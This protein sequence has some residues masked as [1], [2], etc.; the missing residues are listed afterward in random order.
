MKR[1]K[2]QDFDPESILDPA[3]S[4]SED[5]QSAFGS[6]SEADVETGRE[7]YESVGKSKLRKKEVVPLGPQY[8]GSRVRRDEVEDDDSDDPFAR[9]Y[10][11]SDEDNEDE[12]D[13]GDIGSDEDMDNEELGDKDSEDDEEGNEDDDDNESE[14][15]ESN[16]S[17]D[18]TTDLASKLHSLMNEAKTVNATISAGRKADESKGIAIKTQRKIFDSLLNTRVKLQK[19]LVATNS[20]STAS[21]TESSSDE[22][23]AAA[24]AACLALLSTLTNLRTT[25]DSSRIGQKRKRVNYEPTTSSSEIRTRLRQDDDA[26]APHRDAVLQKWYTKTRSTKV[27]SKERLL[28]A[29]AQQT[30]PDVLATQLQNPARL[31]E[32]TRVNRQAGSTNSSSAVYDDSDWYSLLLKD[33]LENRSSE[34]NGSAEFVVRQPWEMIRQ[35]KTKKVV[36]TK[37]SKGR[38]LRYTVHEKLQNFMAPE[39]RGTWGERQRDDLFAGLFGRRAGLA[40]DEPEGSEDE[41]FNAEEDGL[42]LFRS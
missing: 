30:L 32:R 37:A 41:Q 3:P 23:M 22:A 40:E 17:E 36:D 25:L 33:L 31:I 9:S 10:D 19:G 14:D 11:V 13:D 18:A 38:R 8:T 39:E 20:I 4:S 16:D 12:E 42:M 5:E 15:D 27:Q 1:G 29:S 6:D 28:Q 7:H 26:G 2:L 21:R 35:A 24:E 34:L